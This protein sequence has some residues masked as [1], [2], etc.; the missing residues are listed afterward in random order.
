MIKTL[1]EPHVPL[2]TPAARVARLERLFAS[3][4][5]TLEEMLMSFDKPEAESARKFN[6]K[7]SE[8]QSLHVSI[9]KAHEVFLEKFADTSV[10][11]GI[12]YDTIRDDIGGQLDR[13]RGALDAD[14]VS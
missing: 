10:D 2:E 6:L 14:R 12:N 4:F 8:V 11:D 5:G 1:D 9:N 13:I 3:V 7:L